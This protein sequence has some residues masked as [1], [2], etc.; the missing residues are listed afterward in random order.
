MKRK[1][2][3]INVLVLL[4]FIF[5]FGNASATLLFRV[6]E[7]NGNVDPIIGAN[8]FQV[9]NLHIDSYTIDF[10]TS[11][12]F[13]GDVQNELL[14]GYL[15]DRPL[16]DIVSDG[17]PLTYATLSYGFEFE[18]TSPYTDMLFTY[19]RY[20][21]ES[22]ELF[23]ELYDN[24]NPH[25]IS[26]PGEGNYQVLDFILGDVGV[27]KHSINIAYMGEGAKNGHYVDFFELNGNPVPAPEPAT[28]LLLGTGL[29][30]LVGF[31]RR[32]FKKS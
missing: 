7:V 3:C 4:S 24:G 30:G 29:V 16:G 32:K 2:M 5:L 23:S 26:G 21:S 19:G 10:G 13:T 14:P 20:G 28:L 12:P 17:R 9:N 8:E 15:S 11:F 6:G 1:L 31:G 18:L 25:T 27:G 22:D